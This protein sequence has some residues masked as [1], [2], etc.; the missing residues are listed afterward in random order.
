MSKVKIYQFKTTD[1]RIRTDVDGEEFNLKLLDDKL[2]EG[3][4]KK[5]K[6]VPVHWI[7]ESGKKGYKQ[8][9]YK[10]KEVRECLN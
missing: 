10:L 4:M 7:F 5:E 1:G 3:W 2:I 6:I 8:I 9:D